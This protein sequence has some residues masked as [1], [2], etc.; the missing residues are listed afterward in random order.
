M[1]IN[2]AD[3]AIR[4]SEFEIKPVD[5]KGKKGSINAC[6]YCPFRDCCYRKDDAYKRIHVQ[7][8]K[9]EAGSEGEGESNE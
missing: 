2:R 8:A 7:S 5:A 3:E 1:D 6:D 9:E 4:N